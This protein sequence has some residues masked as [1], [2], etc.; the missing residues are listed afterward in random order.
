M[1][2]LSCVQHCILSQTIG[3][4][5]CLSAISILG[6]KSVSAAST[7]DGGGGSDG[8][9]DDIDQMYDPETYE[10]CAEM[11]FTGDGPSNPDLPTWDGG[12]TVGFQTVE[13]DDYPYS[14]RIYDPTITFEYI[15]YPGGANPEITIQDTYMQGDDSPD[16]ATVQY[17]LDLMWDAIAP[18]PSPFG[19]VSG[20]INADL[21]SDQEGFEVSYAGTD[22]NGDTIGG[23]AF[24]HGIVDSCELGEYRVRAEASASVHRYDPGDYNINYDDKVVNLGNLN[25]SE[26]FII[27]L[28]SCSG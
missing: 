9:P 13:S 11:E 3:S 16:D 14:Y 5:I 26:E 2:S 28:E 21:Y 19:L 4:S 17:A 22:W 24:N 12:L 1:L 20:G 27:K 23:I 8:W 7:I 6:S 25:E 10:L 18:I 15:D